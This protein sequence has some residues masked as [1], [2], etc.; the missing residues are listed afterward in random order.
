MADKTTVSTGPTGRLESIDALRGFD[1][2][3]IIGGDVALKAWAKWAGWPSPALVGQQLEHVQWEGFRFYDLIF[4]L[5]LFLVGVVIPFSQ[6]R[7][8][9]QGASRWEMHWRILRRTLLLFALGLLTNRILQFDWENLRVAGVL[10]RIAICYGIAAVIVLNSNRRGQVL[11]VAAI[12]LGYWALL[13]LVPAPGSAAGDYSI[14]GNL[15]GYVDRHYLP[16]KIMKEYYGYGDNEGLLSTFPAVATTLLGVLAGHWLRSGR[17]PTTR[18]LGLTL[19][20]IGCL[21]VGTAWGTV[22]PVI[23]NLWTSSYVLVAGG[24]SLLLLAV[25]HGIIDI[26]GWRRWAF[27]FTVIGANAILIY[28]VPRFVDFQKIATFFLGGVIRHTGSFGPVVLAIGVLAAEW[29][30]LLYLYRRRLFLRV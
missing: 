12:L 30:L 4:P 21:L 20:G 2:F 7:Q 24:W 6:E 8:R 22:F 29:L 5:F 13:A 17:A 19:A 27:F 11:V 9:E 18:L 10:Q 25:F 28:V 16:G 26:L 1:M 23:K 14:E 3:W 15:A